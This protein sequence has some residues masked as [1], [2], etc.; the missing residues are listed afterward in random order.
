M[1]ARIGPCDAMPLRTPDRAPCLVPELVPEWA[2][3]AAL[4]YSEAWQTCLLLIAPSPFLNDSLRLSW[5][6][7]GLLG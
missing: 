5:S 1:P 2:R 4:C 7:S 6:H 3:Q